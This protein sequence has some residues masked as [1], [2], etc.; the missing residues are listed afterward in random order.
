MSDVLDIIDEAMA[1]LE[2][3]RIER[4]AIY[5]RWAEE[6]RARQLRTDLPEQA[7]NIDEYI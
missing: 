3:C 5:R 6:D 4:E 1:L 7:P 2:R